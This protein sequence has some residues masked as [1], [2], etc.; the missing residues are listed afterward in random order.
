MLYR[1]AHIRCRLGLGVGVS[2]AYA[3]TLNIQ[4]SFCVAA[5]DQFFFMFGKRQGF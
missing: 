2:I 3:N 4:Y 1:K 5:E